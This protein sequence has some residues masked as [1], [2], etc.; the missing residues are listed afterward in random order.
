MRRNLTSLVCVSVA[1]VL[2]L[3]VALAGCGEPTSTP[4]IKLGAVFPL[5][6]TIGQEQQKA[7]QLAVMEINSHGGL[8]GR[9][10]T[11]TVYDDG[12]DP[13]VAAA[14]V[15]KLCT[16]DNVNVLLG[17]M[18]S[19]TS[20]GVAPVLKTYQKATVWLGGASH[21]FE[22]A[23][24]G[25]D[26][27]FH[28]HPWDY[29][30]AAQQWVALTTVATDN[31]C[32]LQKIFVAYEDSAFG[33]TSYALLQA[34]LV[35]LGY[36]VTGQSFTSAY[37]GGTGDFGSLVD[38]ANTFDP[39][40]FAVIGYDADILP[41]LGAMKEQAFN[42]PL[43]LGAPP[44]WPVNF[45]SDPLSEG[46]T[47]FTMW[48]PALKDISPAAQTFYYAYIA[49]YHE[50]PPDYIGPLTYDNVMIVAD[51]IQ[52]AGSLDKAALITAL[53]ATDY[54]SAV[55]DDDVVFAPS[56]NITHQASFTVKLFQW[57]AGV[58]EIIY[59]Y[60]VATANFTYP[61]PAWPS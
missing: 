4:S 60:E 55:G 41:L 6:T 21:L 42:P 51:A 52:R 59:P 40:Y 61:H 27:F 43:I 56:N 19:A 26:W 53:E 50:A 30:Q 35:P 20:L 49:E 31:S 12:N 36:N 45:G 46:I 28:I 23:M 48:T 47:G 13:T 14:A 39:D 24:V 38:A 3:G 58:A 18:A 17:G 29:M 37:Y 54:D 34:S 32:P 5:S 11:L 8:L 57:Q 1:L 22:E 15:T 16:V 9:N 2:M 10:V 7:A 33:S 25:C 44:S